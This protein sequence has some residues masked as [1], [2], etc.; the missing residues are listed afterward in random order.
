MQI[1]TALRFHLTPIRIAKSK[2]QVI[3]HTDNDVE[4]GE[5]S[6]F[7][8]WSANLYKHFV[9]QF[10]RFSENCFKIQLYQSWAYAQKMSHHT[11]GTLVPVYS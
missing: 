8:G 1:K 4:Q 6:S 7:A 9:Y 5:Y 2:P 3:A 11:T 10:G